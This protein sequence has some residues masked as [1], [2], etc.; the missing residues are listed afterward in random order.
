[1]YPDIYSA[2]RLAQQISAERVQAARGRRL[3]PHQD[4]QHLER[5]LAGAGH[6]RLL[7]WRTMLSRVSRRRALARLR[8]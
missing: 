3:Q 1:M 2:S 7:D 6:R 5:H 8:P 4:D